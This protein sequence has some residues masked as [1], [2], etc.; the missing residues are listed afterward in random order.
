LNL[1]RA[2]RE[3]SQAGA[4][5]PQRLIVIGNRPPA[6]PDAI[7][8]GRCQRQFAHGRRHLDG[9][10]PPVARLRPFLTD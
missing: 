10:P 5:L 2:L 3:N 9:C 8:V 1:I 6:E 7:L 4:A